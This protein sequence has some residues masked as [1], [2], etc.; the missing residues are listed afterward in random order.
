MHIWSRRT[1]RLRAGIFSTAWRLADDGGLRTTWT[2]L[3]TTAL[4]ALGKVTPND[5][6]ELVMEVLPG[7]TSR[8]ALGRDDQ[9]IRASSI[10]TNWSKLWVSS[11][12]FADPPLDAVAHD[13]VADFLRNGDADARLA[14]A[15]RE[16]LEDEPLSMDAMTLALDAQELAPSEDPTVLREGLVPSWEVCPDGRGRGFK[17]R[18]HRGRRDAGRNTALELGRRLFSVVLQRRFLG[19]P[20]GQRRRHRNCVAR[21]SARASLLRGC[22]CQ[23]LTSLPAAIRED[24]AATVGGHT[25]AEAMRVLPLA[26]MGLIGSLGHEVSPE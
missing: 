8:V 9:V 24:L 3:V 25:R 1:R 6:D 10:A 12:R 15:T 22:D 2:A 5:R 11:E 21:A 7:K 16:E 14:L 20:Y 19:G 18:D 26:I 17:D 4:G 13:G 23:A